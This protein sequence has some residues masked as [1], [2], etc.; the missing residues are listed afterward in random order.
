M[1]HNIQRFV[2]VFTILMLLSTLFGVPTAKA[3]T[4]TFRYIQVNLTDEESETL[5]ESS[6]VYEGITYY[7]VRESADVWRFMI[8]AEVVDDSLIDL[9][10]LYDA[11]GVP[12]TFSPHTV[13]EAYPVE[14]EE[15]PVVTEPDP[16]EEVTP[17]VEPEPVVEEPTTEPTLPKL[18]VEAI[19]IAAVD[20]AVVG[21]EISYTFIVENTGD[22]PMTVTEFSHEYVSGDIDHQS[23][24]SFN[25]HVFDRLHELIGEDGLLPGER[26]EVTEVLAIQ[27]GYSFDAHPEIG[28]VFRVTGV[29][30]FD[31]VVTSESQQII[32]LQTPDF[33]VNATVE[34]ATVQPGEPVRYTYTITNPSRVTLFLAKAVLTWPS[35]ALTKEEQ[36]LANQRFAELVEA[37]PAFRDGLGPEEEV[38]FSFELPLLTSYDMRA[39]AELIQ[40]ATFTFEVDEGIAVTHSVDV[41]VAVKQPVPVKEE[42]KQDA[43]KQ[44]TEVKTT[45]PAVTVVVKES[46]AKRVEHI[47]EADPYA[48]G[49]LPM[50]G[51]ADDL[52][53]VMLGTLLFASGLL[54]LIR[55]NHS[56]TKP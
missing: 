46:G 11:E 26:V 1:T 37:I 21:G 51:E 2:A 19:N 33:T 34:K 50:T 7:G 29:D 38:T 39:G 24:E 6:L 40:R 12:Y 35:G 31:R 52:W 44:K 45:P 43:N 30:E 3:D 9:I 16:S 8:D 13:T 53:H 25:Q 15:P 28:S 56:S 4:T 22:T 36:H 10:T 18:A 49:V 48:Q 41:P 42:P 20:R 14:V 27:I 54:L 5:Y 47:D 32:L 17:P 23:I 55:R